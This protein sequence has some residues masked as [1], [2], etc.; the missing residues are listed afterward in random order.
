MKKAS[1][2]SSLEHRRRAMKRARSRGRKRTEAKSKTK[3][4]ADD[5]PKVRRRAVR[6]EYVQPKDAENATRDADYKADPEPSRKAAPAEMPTK[7]AAK[8]VVK[9]TKPATPAKPDF[10]PQKTITVGIERKTRLMIKW[11]SRLT[12]LTRD[13]TYDPDDESGAM[14]RVMGRIETSEKQQTTKKL[15]PLN[16]GTA[17]EALKLIRGF[18]RT[19]RSAT[20]ST[21]HIDLKEDFK[22]WFQTEDDAKHVCVEAHKHLDY[23]TDIQTEFPFLKQPLYAWQ[24]AAMLFLND[25]TRDGRGAILADDTGLGKSWEL[26]AHLAW[27]KH[28]QA[29]G[30]G[31]AL[32]VCPAALRL[33]WQRKIREATRLSTKVLDEKYCLD[34]N[35]YD[36]LITSYASLR[37]VRGKAS[38][39]RSDGSVSRGQGATMWY[40][41]PLMEKQ[42]RVLVMDEGHFA[43][44]YDSARAQ[45]CAFLAEY[46]K[47]SV[48]LTAT[49]LKNRIKELHPIL[50]ITR[51]LWTGA[52]MKEFVKMYDHPDAQSEIAERLAGKGGFMVRRL[53]PEV[54]TDAPNGRVV[55]ADT[56]LT[57]WDDYRAVETNF[58]NWLRARGDDE[59]KIMRA[60]RG[61]VL[62][63]LN[64]L[65]QLAANG[66]CIHASKMIHNTLKKGEQVVV[67]SAFN[68]P[69]KELARRYKVKTGTNHKGQ[70][71]KGSALIIGGQSDRKRMEVIDQ[72][73]AGKIGLLCVGVTAGGFGI[74]LPAARV[75]YFMDLP[76]SPADFEQCTGRLLRLGQDRD[77]EF[78]KL[79]APGTVD[80]RLEAIIFDKARTFQRAIGDEGIV[81]RIMGEDVHAVQH[82][83]VAQVVSSYLQEL[84]ARG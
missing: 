20:G 83:V 54:W 46:A 64:M 24:S 72:F 71:W 34:A 42:Q 16:Y 69:L 82:S 7:R 61:Y 17:V 77:C 39:E 66:K 4:C 30:R 5:A 28:T 65:R 27:L 74:D 49:P 31:K 45:M 11:P 33:P 1:K 52:S 59:D 15:A 40:L 3:P 70:P 25:V 79:V 47:H 76:W 37:K 60:E 41:A 18:V 29:P 56:E 19:F 9:R 73:Q 68:Y 6:N 38:R 58:L 21:F 12:N 14:C 75:A 51:R 53:T 67:F 81:D 55:R 43:K 48:V 26:A 44:N 63:Q 80:E 84:A 23:A 62:T 2:R 50:R 32:I 8:R 35:K 13:F 36:V 22:A 78:V 57:N 10:D